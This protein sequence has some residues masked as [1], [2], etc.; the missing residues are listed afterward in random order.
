MSIFKKTTDVK[1]PV[2]WP[3][4]NSSPVCMRCEENKA[5]RPTMR[6]HATINAFSKLSLFSFPS[7]PLNFL[8]AVS[9]ALDGNFVQMRDLFTR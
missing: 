4:Y 2:E 3:I 6:P 8:W 9:R 5:Q 1:D 7:W